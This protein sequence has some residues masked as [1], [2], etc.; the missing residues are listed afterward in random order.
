MQQSINTLTEVAKK[1][2]IYSEEMYAYPNYALATYTGAQLYGP[3]NAKRMRK[4]RERVDP[5]GVMLLA[6]GFTF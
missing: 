5:Q 2:G 4:I 3:V 6:G 1:E